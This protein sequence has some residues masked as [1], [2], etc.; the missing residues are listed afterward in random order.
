[1]PHGPVR[2]AGESIRSLVTSDSIPQ[3]WEPLLSQQN[4]ISTVALPRESPALLPCT[5]GRSLSCRPI[6][7]SVT[8]SPQQRSPRP[9]LPPPA[10][11]WLLICDKM[12]V[13]KGTELFM[14]GNQ[15]GPASEEVVAPGCLGHW[16]HWLA[17]A[18]CSRTE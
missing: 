6:Q 7:L 18:M 12:V 15:S 1:M 3:P 16:L 10:Y 11:G 17:S 5:L 13:G 9:E 8:Y 14:T 4:V 2:R